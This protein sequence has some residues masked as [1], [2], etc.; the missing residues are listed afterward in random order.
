MVNVVANLYEDNKGRFW[1]LI[2]TDDEI[3]DYCEEQDDIR[4][5]E[6]I[7]E[8]YER[9]GIIEYLDDHRASELIRQDVVNR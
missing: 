5:H 3:I 7:Q 8:L 6:D 9:L 4:T 2:D 1:K